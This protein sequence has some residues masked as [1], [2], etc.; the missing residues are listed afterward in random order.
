DTCPSRAKKPFSAASN[1]ASPRPTRAACIS[2][3]CA[4]MA[5]EALIPL[6]PNSSFGGRFAGISRGTA[7]RRRTAAQGCADR[8]RERRM[9]EEGWGEGTTA[10]TTAPSVRV[11]APPP[12]PTHSPK[13]A[14][15]SG[16]LALWILLL[17]PLFSSAQ[18]ALDYGPADV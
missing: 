10:E 17:F 3:R 16:F 1:S 15:R 5:P 8:T 13:R 4:C 7:A 14:W 2:S 9:R 18:G 11:H 12:H 6:S